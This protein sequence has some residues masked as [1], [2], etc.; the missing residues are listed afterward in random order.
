MPGQCLRR[1][2]TTSISPKVTCRQG[3]TSSRV[4]KVVR[5]DSLVRIHWIQ[6]RRPG[7][8]AWLSAHLWVLVR[9]NE[10]L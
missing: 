3:V 6:R 1:C 5:V 7:R 9:G 10:N 2:R 8:I 4:T